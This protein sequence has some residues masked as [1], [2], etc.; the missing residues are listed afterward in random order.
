MKNLKDS[1]TRVINKQT[2]TLMKM[3]G[4]I[5]DL[6]LQM[7]AL[8]EGVRSGFIRVDKDI[9]VLD[10]RIDRRREECERTEVA[11]RIAE[12]KIGVLE[13][14][15]RTQREMIKKLMACVEA[16]EGRLCRCGKGKDRQV[17][18]EVSPVLDSPIVLG[19]EVLEDN[20]SNDSYHTPPVASSFVG[21]SSSP[22]VS[23]QDNLMVLYDSRV[24]HLEEIQDDA[25]KENVE[26]VAVPSPILDMAGL[27][28]LIAVRGQRAVRSLGPPK[29]FHPYAFCCDIGE[30][31]S[32]HRPGR[33]CLRL[34][35]SKRERPFQGGIGYEG[36]SSPSQSER[37]VVDDE[38]WS[39][40]F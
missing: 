33:F 28:R 9:E 23:D 39:S 5:T 22:P 25:P 24:S 4:E 31:S 19:Q 26:P 21:P 16:M 1:H 2:D 29:S 30:R 13:E 34:K 14:R 8:D 18:E 40:S 7:D 32:T 36:P 27:S 15:S 38:G 3:D 20:A 11:L 17:L 10:K 35:A 37:G 12:G 6:S